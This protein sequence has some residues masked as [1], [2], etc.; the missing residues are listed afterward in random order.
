MFNDDVIR[1]IRGHAL[2]DYP[3]ES[4]GLVIEID[5]TDIYLPRNNVAADPAAAFRIAPQ[6]WVAASRK[7]GI[8]AVVHSHPDGPDCPSGEDMRRQMDSAVP[9]GIVTTNGQR[10]LEPFWFGDTVQVPD[11]V[12]RG[13]RHGVTDCFSLIRDWYWIERNIRLPA[14][15]RDWEWWAD[16][17]DDNNRAV[18]GH[19]DLYTD[20]FKPAG[21]EKINMTEAAHGDVFLAQTP[22]SP[23][24]NH[25]GIYLGNG[26]ALHH[27]AG[28]QAVDLS[29]LS[30]REP[31]HRW[32]QYL[33]HWL[34]Y[35]TP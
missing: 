20:G 4:A 31:I 32:R 22:G 14:F 3:N 17:K 10:C 13:F 15:P 11:L 25:G 8:R 28:K 18:E 16:L 27:L 12:G 5:G 26:L 19:L 34:R 21:F 6:A 2:I 29:R 33:T 23:V 1:D 24:V 30:V 9:W 35:T 7:G